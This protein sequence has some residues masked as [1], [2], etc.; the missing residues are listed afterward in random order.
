MVTTF[1]ARPGKVVRRSAPVRFLEKY[2]YFSMSLLIAAIVVYGFS[3][4][5]GDNL[6]HPAI[7]R[8]LLLAI[9]GACFSAWVL[10]FI[11][12][13]ALVRTRNVRLHKLTGWFGAALAAAMILLGYSIAVVMARFK[14][15][16]LHQPDAVPFL[17]IPLLDISA[18][19]CTIVPAILL[20]RK[21]ELHR[22]FIYI[23][24]CALTGA[25]FGRFPTDYFPPIYFYWGVDALIVIGA[26]RDLAVTRRIHKIYLY[27]LPLLFAA[28]CAAMYLDNHPPHFWMRIAGAIVG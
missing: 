1:P 23:A 10:F 5:I 3:H 22:H 14:F 20:R 19:A 15:H 24:T 25:A 12:Q 26:L 27:T 16:V 11:F 4:T 17:I 8:P 9:H 7:P 21:P 18:F 13:S 2:F 6:F 28:Q